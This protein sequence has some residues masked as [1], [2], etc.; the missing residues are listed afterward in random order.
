[1]AWHAVLRAEDLPL[2][3][4][5]RVEVLGQPILLARL[6]DGW[7]AVHDTCLHRGAS[8]AAGALEDTRVT[9][10]LHFWV[11]DVRDGTCAQ[12]P[13][14]ALKVFPVKLEEGTV[15]VDV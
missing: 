6:D 3:G 14:L 1:M 9:C 10:P 13:G 7:H 5:R 12:V 15:Y 11:F 8:L 4:H 2:G